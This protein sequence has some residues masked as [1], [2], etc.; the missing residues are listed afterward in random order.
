MGN[1]PLYRNGVLNNL[2]PSFISFQTNVQVPFISESEWNENYQKI[3]KE[4][5][6]KGDVLDNN[7]KEITFPIVETRK[8]TNK[9]ANLS[10]GVLN[11]VDYEFS[12]PLVL[13]KEYEKTQF[14]QT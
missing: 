13:E 7:S 1:L 14:S 11:Q 6:L 10:L 9:D 12:T 2:E 3:K 4:S 5:L 8:P